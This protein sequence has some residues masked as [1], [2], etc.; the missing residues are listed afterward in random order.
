MGGAQTDTPAADARLIG[1]N[2]QSLRAMLVAA[3]E[4][5]LLVDDHL[6]GPVEEAARSIVTAA[7]HSTEAPALLF[8]GETTVIVRG[9]GQGGRNQELALRV[10]LEAK[11]QRLPGPW[12]FLSGGTDGRDGPTAAAGGCVDDQTLARLFEAGGDV[13]ALLDESDSF[14]A[15]SLSGE[16]IPEWATGTN[17]ADVQVLLRPDVLASK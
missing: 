8:G 16:I 4:G 3:P 7:R 14:R 15:L 9:K 5:A 11:R 13:L 17:V 12:V 10:A 1:S 6:T 2:R